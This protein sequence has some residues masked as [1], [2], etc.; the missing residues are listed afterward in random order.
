MV[1][2]FVLEVDD[3]FDGRVL[4]RRMFV[5]GIL[6]NIIRVGLRVDEKVGINVLIVSMILF[7]V[8]GLLDV[9]LEDV[10]ICVN[11]LVKDFVSSINE[12]FE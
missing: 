7:F 9:K 11:K 10:C 6:R 2:E 1:V 5:C 3:F 12:R 4:L 8:N